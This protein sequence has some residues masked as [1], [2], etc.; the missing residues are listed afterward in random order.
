M[1]LIGSDPVELAVSVEEFGGSMPWIEADS[2]L[3]IEAYLRAAQS[4]VEVA[5]RRI[6]TPRSVAF[7]FDLSDADGFCRWWFPVAPIVEVTAI[8]AKHPLK[9]D[10]PVLLADV[11]LH[12]GFE[13]PQLVFDAPA[14]AIACPGLAESVRVEA[15][16]GYDTDPPREALKHAIILLVKEWYDAGVSIGELAEANVAFG[17]QALIRQRRYQ[18]P[19]EFG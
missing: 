18:R 9:A 16:V 1:Q 3:T 2:T 11:G 10:V 8:A 13:E 7:E 4:V 15:T 19:K 6:L 12:R 5:S 17:V 14:L